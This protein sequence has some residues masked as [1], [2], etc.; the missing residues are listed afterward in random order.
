MQAHKPDQPNQK[1][2]QSGKPTQ[3]QPNNQAQQQ[4]Q[5]RV[6]YVNSYQPPEDSK[7]ESVSNQTQ[8]SDQDQAKLKSKA[9]PMKDEK[10]Q[11]PKQA[12]VNAQ[13]SSASQ[14]KTAEKETEAESL[15]EQN[16]FDLLG[17][18][19]GDREEKEQFLD[20][21]QQVIWEDFLE[22]DLD[23]LVTSEEKKDIDQILGND[24]LDDFQKQDKVIEYLDGLIPDLEEIMLEKALELKE[25]LVYERVEAMRKFYAEDE[26]TQQE[27]KQ[28]VKKFSTNQWASGA[29]ILNQIS[30]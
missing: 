22:N 28:A 20:E 25:E 11:Q 8:S 16:I 26:K 4:K 7:K 17:V 24:N 15:E 19:D 18:D 29:K 13:K 12:Q 21:L 5:S 14:S 27:I 23:L 9:A 10:N 1:S 2:D 30:S 6:D 3:A